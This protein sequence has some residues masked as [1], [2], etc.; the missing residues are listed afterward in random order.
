LQEFSGAEWRDP[1]GLFF[2][3]AASR[4]SHEDAG[5]NNV[6]AQKGRLINRG[7]DFFL[8]NQHAAN[9]G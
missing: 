2:F 5:S 6:A 8:P 3:I 1:E 7:S 9:D 4:R